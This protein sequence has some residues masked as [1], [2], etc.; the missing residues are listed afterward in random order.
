LC[1]PG[2]LR[3]LAAAR[4]Q[5]ERLDRV[6]GTV[7]LDDLGDD[8]ADALGGLLGGLQRRARPY[9]GRAFRLHLRDLDRALRA[10]RFEVTLADALERVGP[11]LDPRPRRRALERAK[12]DAFWE[13][14]RRH[15]LCLA[16]PRV[17]EW[18]EQLQAR[19]RHGGDVL[20]VLEVGARLPAHPTL[21]RTRLAAEATGDPHALDDDRPL[22]RL[23]TAQLAFRAG[24]AR[25]D[26]ALARRELW[27]RFGVL[28]D[29]ASADV[30]V[31]GLCPLPGGPL[32]SALRA[33]AGWHVRLTLGQL[34]RERL[35]FPPGL[36]VSVC[37][38][39]T[40]LTAA[41]ERYAERCAPLVCVEGWPSSAAWTLVDA[42]AASGATFRYHGDFDWDGLRIAALVRERTG[43]RPWRFDAAG[44]SSALERHAEKT[45]PL[46]GRASVVTGDDPLQAALL[47]AGRELHEEVVL[48]DLLD[49]L[50]Q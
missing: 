29:A 39:V 44:Y 19:G 17:V 38:N 13:G 27:Q 43:A 35:R 5:V 6:G 33:L 31:L 34:A 22:S 45:R 40:V 37:E 4:E 15:P 16:E 48:E 18:L 20:Q 47:S 32:A 1:Q 7:V 8:E 12:R 9:P 50:A 10:S 25:P 30:L 28:L 41:E 46:E 24:E 26:R 42:L 2:L 14:A 23:L 11:P 49:D 36:D 21:E 3:A